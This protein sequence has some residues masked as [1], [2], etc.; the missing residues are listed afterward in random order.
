MRQ[1]ETRVW[2]ISDNA[3]EY[4]ASLV[5]EMLGEMGM[6]HIQSIPYK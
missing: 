2:F 1:E 4:T 3:G 5:R 6:K